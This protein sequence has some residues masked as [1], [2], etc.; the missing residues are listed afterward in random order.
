[1]ADPKAKFKKGASVRSTVEIPFM[2]G[3]EV[4]TVDMAGVIEEVLEDGMVEVD[5]S[6]ISEFVTMSLDSLE[7]IDEGA[8]EVVDD[9]EERA[10][11]MM[12]EVVEELA[13]VGVDD[14]GCCDAD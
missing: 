12:D 13:E 14:G 8:E 6:D 1:M 7:L 5:F 2:D 3:D 10:T 4:V 9:A 11:G